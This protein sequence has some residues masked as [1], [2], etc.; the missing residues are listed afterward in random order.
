MYITSLELQFKDKKADGTLESFKKQCVTSYEN[1]SL[2]QI[3]QMT[4][5]VSRPQHAKQKRIV[6]RI[7]IANPTSPVCQLN[8]KH[9]TGITTFKSHQ[10]LESHQ[11]LVTFTQDLPHFTTEGAKLTDVDKLDQCHS[12]NKW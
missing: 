1:L 6:I 3:H 4:H 8:S 9:F 12:P 2:C 11:D 7:L 5:R 10:I